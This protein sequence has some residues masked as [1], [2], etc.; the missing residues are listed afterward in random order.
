VGPGR[1]RPGER[2]VELRARRRVVGTL[3]LPAGVVF[4]AGAAARFLPALGSLLAVATDREELAREALEAEALRRSDSIKT[5]LLRAVSHDLRSPLT[6]I[7]VAVESLASPALVLE[8]RHRAIYAGRE[9]WFD[10]TPDLFQ[11]YPVSHLL[12]A[13]YNDELAWY[14]RTF[15]EVMARARLLKIYHVWKTYLFLYSLRDGESPRALYPTGDTAGYD[16]AVDRASFPFAVEP[17]ATFRATIAWRNVGSQPW[18]AADRVLLAARD[19]RDPFTAGRHPL[20]TPRA[21][22]AEVVG[23]SLPMQAPARPGLYVTSWQMVKEG[24]FRFGEPYLAV[25]WVR[26]RS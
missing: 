17:E 10:A 20:P 4:D 11:R 19:D 8:N 1:P 6:A 2:P 23:F 5:A 26:P 13:T 9:G 22:P 18:Q 3:Y 21:A 12:L 25:I 14:Y 16:A 24:A 7:R 15:P